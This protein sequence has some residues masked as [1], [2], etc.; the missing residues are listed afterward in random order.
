MSFCPIWPFWKFW[1]CNFHDLKFPFKALSPFRRE[2]TGASKVLGLGKES[3]YCLFFKVL[4]FFLFIVVPSLNQVCYWTSL[5]ILCKCIPFSKRETDLWIFIS[6]VGDIMDED[7]CIDARR[8]T[9]NIIYF[10]EHFDRSLF[11]CSLFFWRDF[12]GIR[13]ICPHFCQISGS[14]SGLLF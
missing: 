2:G 5:G 1:K 11:S 8:G 6:A 9:Y 14:L 13:D 10:L 4:S 7:L 12:S 3:L